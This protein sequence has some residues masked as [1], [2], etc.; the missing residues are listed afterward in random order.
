V[1]R[2]EAINR[3]DPH[4]SKRTEAPCRR[5]R[6]L[7]E[8]EWGVAVSAAAPILLIEGVVLVKARCAVARLDDSLE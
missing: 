4:Q 2:V 1:W 7:A 6:M 8:T 5:L 3:N